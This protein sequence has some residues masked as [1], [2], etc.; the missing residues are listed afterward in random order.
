MIEIRE[1]TDRLK[2]KEICEKAGVVFSGDVYMRAMFDGGE[3]IGCCLV[4]IDGDRAEVLYFEPTD[5]I[6]LAD[7]IL[8]ASYR[9]ALDHGCAEVCCGDRADGRLI[10]R[11]GFIADKRTGRLSID[12][13]SRECGKGV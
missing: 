12:F 7:G 13:N 4:G 6:P 3:Q 8:R 5:D 1:E 10:E 9:F 2:I 11:L